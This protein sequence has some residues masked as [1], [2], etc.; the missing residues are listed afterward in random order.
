MN[1]AFNILAATDLSAPARHAAERAAQV[2]A[3]TGGRLAIVHVANLEP[4][5]QLQQWLASEAGELEA[6]LL[7]QA[8]AELRRLGET[9]HGRFGT[10][11]SLDVVAGELLPRLLERAS[12]LPADLMVLGARG[13]SFLRR[14]LLGSTAE[15]LLGAAPL[16]MLV[17]RQAV[18]EPYR[19]LLVTVDFSPRAL[20]ALRCAAR[21][22]PG[23]AITVLHVVELPF[24]GQL[25]YAG[26]AEDKI[27]HYRRGGL[28]RARERLAELCAAA[29]LPRVRPLAL[30]GDA[31]LTIVAQE[32]ELDSDLIVVG[33]HGERPFADLLLGSVCKHVLAE[34]QGDV[35]VV[36]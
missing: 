29:G 12:A 5:A 7:E 11:A 4:L 28:A 21:L 16:P 15:R 23:A 10:A 8:R 19:R 3:A 34:A 30:A 26:V 27:D 13:G 35:L 2:A 33:K 6:E 9:L 24:E 20:R 17:V 18:H 36:P 22:A 14:L 31:S 25:R 1:T 32:Q